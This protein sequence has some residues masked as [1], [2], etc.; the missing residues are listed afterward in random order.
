MSDTLLPWYFG[1][2]FDSFLNDITICRNIPNNDLMPSYQS[3]LKLG[4][5]LICRNLAR[6]A[7]VIG[8][9]EG[10]EKKCYAGL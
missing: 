7:V 1:M 5:T 4:S 3:V 9:G 8:K 6:V 10:S 2:L